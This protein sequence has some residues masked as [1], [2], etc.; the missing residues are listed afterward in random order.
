MTVYVSQL[1]LQII[2]YILGVILEEIIPGPGNPHE[3]SRFW[4]T[5]FWKLEVDERGTS[6]VYRGFAM[7][8]KTHV[9]IF[10]WLKERTRSVT[11]A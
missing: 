6:V 10:F 4:E 9:P 2:A 3:R 7:T 1:F 8:R 11:V 5:A